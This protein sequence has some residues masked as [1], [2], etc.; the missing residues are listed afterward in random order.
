[1]KKVITLLLTLI[2][3]LTI[4]T[5]TFAAD[6]AAPGVPSPFGYLDDD[7]TESSAP[8]D[9]V[10]ETNETEEETV[11]ETPAQTDTNVHNAAA[12]V[13]N[14]TPVNLPTSGPALNLL[15]GTSLIIGFF[16]TKRKEWSL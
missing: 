8:P 10:M 11:S 3:T 13:N 16:I 7:T 5:A 4:G 14:S 6:S 15:I 2:A 9:M 12:S 1:M